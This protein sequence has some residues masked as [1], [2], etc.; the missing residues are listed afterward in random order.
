MELLVVLAI[1]G[2]LAVVGI[3]S[4][5]NR[6]GSSV[7]SLLDEVEGSID[8]AH[9]LAAATGRDMAIVDWGSWTPAG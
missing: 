5:G 4:L 8:N 9:Q 6:Q 2:I 7:R 1:I 3:S